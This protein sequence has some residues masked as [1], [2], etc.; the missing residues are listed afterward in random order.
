MYYTEPSIASDYVK[1]KISKSPATSYFGN[2]NILV[3]GDLSHR[4][5]ASFNYHISI[6]L[7]MFNYYFLYVLTESNCLFHTSLLYFGPLLSYFN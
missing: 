5:R 7:L 6:Q 2:Y 4:M 1:Q 3:V